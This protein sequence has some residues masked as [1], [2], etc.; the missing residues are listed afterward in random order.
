MATT[1]FDEDRSCNNGISDDDDN[2]MAMDVGAIDDSHTQATAF[3]M[4]SAKVE[5]CCKIVSLLKAFVI[6]MSFRF[7]IFAFEIMYH[8]F[9]PSISIS[10]L[11]GSAYRSSGSATGNDD[12]TMITAIQTKFK[13]VCAYSVRSVSMCR[14]SIRGNIDLTD[15]TAPRRMHHIISIIIIVLK[16]VIVTVI[17]HYF[18]FDEMYIHLFRI[19]LHS[20]AT[21]IIIE[22]QTE[23]HAPVPKDS[24]VPRQ[25]GFIFRKRRTWNSNGFE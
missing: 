1:P 24:F 4:C 9:N 20:I 10:K 13:F 3:R 7:R 16:V 14:H 18:H 15:C 25:N 17:V 21:T 22:R 2:N 5:Q 11:N 6:S 19:E 12:M 8:Q 23:I